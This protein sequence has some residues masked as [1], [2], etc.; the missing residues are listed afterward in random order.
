MPTYDYECEA[1]G[2]E[3]EK[4][5]AMS[6]EPLNECPECHKLK[7]VKLIGPGAAVIVRG[8]KN[9]CSGI[10]GRTKKNTQPKKLDKLGEGENKREKPFWR[11]GPVNKDILKNPE[12]YIRKGRVD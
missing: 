2:H 8:T 3:F 7:L 11:D 1:C 4:F 12:K 5:H 10:R 6:A 9:L